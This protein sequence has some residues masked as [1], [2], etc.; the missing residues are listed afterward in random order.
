VQ[1]I[2]FH[3]GP[4]TVHWYGILLALGFLAGLW[5]AARRAKLT[6]VPGD[7]ISDVGLWLIIG[8]I[9][10]AR[11]L[12]VVTYWKESFAGQPI[13]EIFMIQRGGLVFY[14]GLIGSALA[15]I[16]YCRREKLPLWKVADVLA[17]SIALGYVFGRLGCLMNGCCFGRECSL[18]WAIHFPASHVTGGAPVHPTQIYDSLLNLVLYAALVWLYRRKKFDGQIFAAYL[19]CYA[20]TR[21]I[22]E[23]F[24][25]DYTEV[26]RHAGLTPAHLISIGIFAAGA[27]LF[28]ILRKRPSRA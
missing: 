15:C 20:I 6:G 12:Y 13:T 14:G 2:A 8:A 17:P 24:R 25:G 10:G 19:M 16:I 1:S 9:L 26:H 4:L 22:V 27:A 7:K 3:L 5:T 18:P 28:A 11:I 21:S 23:T